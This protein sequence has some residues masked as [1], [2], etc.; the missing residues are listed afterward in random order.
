MIKR[1]FTPGFR[2]ELHHKDL[3]IALS[4]ASTLGINLPNT[5]ATQEL[6]NT[7]IAQGDAK[8][9]SSIIIRALEKIANY[10]IQKTQIN[11]DSR[12]CK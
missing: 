6:L 11:A 1:E 12:T 5:T 9:D 8:F 7:C 3:N 4:S 10:E 2:V